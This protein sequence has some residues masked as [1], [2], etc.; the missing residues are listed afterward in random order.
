V[1]SASMVVVGVSGAMWGSVAVT[2]RA[3]DRLM[4]Q[5]ASTAAELSERL[6]AVA[7]AIEDLS[8]EILREAAADGAE[9]P[10]A[11]RVLVRARRSVDKAAMLL[12]GLASAQ[13]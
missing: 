3:Y 6:T 8:F 4:A 10:D 2:S 13:E 1:Y 7:E 9:R 11:D 12:S 5:I